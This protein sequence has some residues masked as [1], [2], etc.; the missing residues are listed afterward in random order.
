MLCF[1]EHENIHETFS[2]TRRIKIEI[3]SST[4]R[5]KDGERSCRIFSRSRVFVVRA[6]LY[7]TKLIR[8]LLYYEKCNFNGKTLRSD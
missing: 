3:F 8:Q 2:S 5:E 6:R 1:S 4:E 7:E